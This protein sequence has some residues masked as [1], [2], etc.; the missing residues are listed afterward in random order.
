MFLSENAHEYLQKLL[1]IERARGFQRLYRH[2][3]TASSIINEILTAIL[4]IEIEKSRSNKFFL[5]RKREEQIFEETPLYIFIER[6]RSEQEIFPAAEIREI[7]L[8]SEG[9]RLKLTENL[10]FLVAGVFGGFVGALLTWAI[11][12]HEVHSSS[13]IPSAPSAISEPRH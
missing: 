7:V 4:E 5:E 9:R 2:L 6:V 12:T 10:A 1:E 8:L 13:T 3:F 11:G